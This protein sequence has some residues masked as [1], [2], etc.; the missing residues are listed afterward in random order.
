MLLEIELDAKRR[1]Q[2]TTI[3]DG[4]TVEQAYYS[5]GKSVNSYKT[6]RLI[7]VFRLQNRTRRTRGFP[8]GLVLAD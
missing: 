2:G 1:V 3:K 8:K 5:N 7:P 6:E 4:G